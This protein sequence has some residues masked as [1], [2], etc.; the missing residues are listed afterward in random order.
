MELD[1]FESGTKS[2]RNTANFIALSIG[3]QVD[4]L[5]IQQNTPPIARRD[6]VVRRLF[7]KEI[8]GE[9]SGTSRQHDSREADI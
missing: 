6:H 1:G 9:L 2:G 7:R 3:F 4:F 8:L 5:D